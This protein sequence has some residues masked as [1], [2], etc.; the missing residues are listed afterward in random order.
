MRELKIGEQIWTLDNLN[1]TSYRNG[2]E[3]PMIEDE[4]DWRNAQIGAWCNFENK[5][6][7]EIV[8]GKL[9]NYYAVIDSRGLAPVGYRIPN[10]YDWLMLQKDTSQIHLQLYLNN[11][12]DFDED[13]TFNSDFVG[14]RDNLGRFCSKGEA[15]GWWAYFETDV[16]NQGPIAHFY[17]KNEPQLCWKPFWKNEGFYI[18]CLKETYKSVELFFSDNIQLEFKSIKLKYTSNTTFQNVLDFLYDNI[19]KGKFSLYT[20]GKEWVIQI[21]N[22]EEIIKLNKQGIVDNRKIESILNPPN[23]TKIKLIVECIL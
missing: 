3:I 15:I 18:K 5:S 7:G 16:M 17:Y 19:L 2:D 4:A 9:Y 1:V 14:Y 8:K 10:H 6:D 21:Y 13:I 12:A 11:K 22:G 20:Y 23:K